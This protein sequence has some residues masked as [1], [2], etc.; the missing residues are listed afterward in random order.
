MSEAARILVVEDS[1]TQAAAL[2]SLLEAAGYGVSVAADGREGLEA[3]RRERPA[4]V[5]SDIV[6]PGLDGYG[7]CRKLK[8]DPS[9]R[10]IPVLLLTSLSDPEDIVR[11]L[12]ARADGYCTKPYEDDLLLAGIAAQLSG[13]LPV[14]GEDERGELE[15]TIGGRRHRVTSTPREIL[16]MLLSTYE[17]AVRQNRRLS[18][19]Q[20][21]LRALNEELEDRVR[22]RTQELEVRQQHLTQALR[23]KETLLKEVHHRVKNNLQLIASLL[24]MQARR[25]DD[26]RQ[27]QVLLDSQSRVQSMAMIHERLYRS[28]SLAEVDFRVYAAALLGELLAAHQPSPGRVAVELAIEDGALGLDAAVPCGLIVNELVTNALKY[29]FPEGRRGTIRIALETQG[30]SNV[31]TVSDDGVGLPAA[32]QPGAAGGQ[33]LGLGLVRLLAEQLEGGMQVEGG[34]QGTRVEVR[35]PRQRPSEA[36][37]AG[38]ITREGGRA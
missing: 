10:Q 16:G 12:E 35:F 24:R 33:G 20:E 30:G 1:R 38:A 26:P 18:E 17:S 19:T 23:E 37:A 13:S 32:I 28:E 34:A 14:G 7:L 21:E 8:A 11:G 3:V 22:E 9:L 2:Q 31:L 5:V 27:Q 29:A 36:L 6:M 25:L 4:L 15:V